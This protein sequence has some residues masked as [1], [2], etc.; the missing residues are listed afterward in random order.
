MNALTRI[1][2][3]SLLAAPGALAE[4]DGHSLHIG[5]DERTDLGL[6]VYS[7]FAIVR[8]VRTTMLPTGLVE[9]EYHGVA[10]TID[11]TS[12][13]TA[14]RGGGDGVDVLRQSYQYDLLN[15]HSLLERYIGRKLKYSRSLVRD[16]GTLEKVF[17][18][19]TLLSIDPEIVQFGD[20]IEISPEGVISLPYIPEGLKTDP[21]LVWTVDNGRRG[22]Q[23]IETQYLANGISWN[24]EYLLVLDDDERRFDLSSWV[25]LTNES[26]T[27]FRDASLKLVAGEVQRAAAKRQPVMYSLARSEMAMDS[28][29]GP[30]REVLADYHLYEFPARVSIRDHE[31]LQL[32]FRDADSVKVEKDYVSVAPV[33]LHQMREPQTGRFD[34]RYTFD[35][36][37]RGSLGEPLPAGRARVMKADSDGNLQLLGESSIPHTALGEDVELQVGKAFDLAIERTQKSWRRIGDRAA[38]VTVEVTVT[39][40]GSERKPLIVHEKFSGDWEVVAQSEAGKKIDA[41]TLEYVLTLGGGKSQTFSYTVR[42]TF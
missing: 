19:G 32:A 28:S 41:A 22:E 1:L 33:A 21:T 3:L 17:R 23:D 40:A 42:S 34:I 27:A 14:T 16:N 36:S 31:T 4:T 10:K 9:L 18:E 5:V 13:R 35:N 7:D 38:E 24:A 30:S 26:G 11:P 37:K 25:N 39:N 29:S 6:T 8:D 15:K 20:S 12:V 2:L